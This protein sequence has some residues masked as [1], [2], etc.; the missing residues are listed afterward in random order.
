MTWKAS[1][2]ALSFGLLSGVQSQ[3]IEDSTTDGRPTC[4]VYS[5]GSPDI[6]DVPTIIDAFDRC[7]TGGNVIFPEDQIYH[8][9]TRLNPTFHDVQIDWRGEWLYSEDLEYWR[10]NSYPI[11]FQNHA[12]GFIITGDDIRIDGHGTGGIDGSGEVWYYDERVNETVGATRPGRPMPFV[13]WNVSDVHVRGFH[14][15]QPPLWS[16]NIMNGT[17][18]IFENIYCNATSPEAPLGY[19]WVQNADGFSKS[20]SITVYKPY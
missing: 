5:G 1:F 11:A 6:D 4:T 18:M 7:G 19:N 12:A 20:T 17:D 3:R 15:V 2:T 8:I 14:V 9:N 16:I 13:F 10:N